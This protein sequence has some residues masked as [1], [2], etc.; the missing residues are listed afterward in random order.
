MSKLLYLQI[1][2][3]NFKPQISNIQILNLK[4]QNGR[5]FIIDYE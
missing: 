5:I 3:S 2:I 4:F 1:Q